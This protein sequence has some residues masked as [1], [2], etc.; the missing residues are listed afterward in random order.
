MKGGDNPPPF[1]IRPEAYSMFLPL[2]LWWGRED[3][4][5]CKTGARGQSSNESAN[6]LCN[7][8]MTKFTWGMT[9]G[10]RSIIY[11]EADWCNRCSF[12][13]PH[14]LL[15]FLLLNPANSILSMLPRGGPGRL[16]SRSIIRVDV[17]CRRHWILS[18]KNKPIGSWPNPSCL[19]ELIG[20]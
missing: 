12:H 6:W 20:W 15:K 1:G 4:V 3:S 14:H 11:I 7:L 10:N 18:A 5:V 16:S 17:I 2:L 9:S 19:A 8:V 13:S